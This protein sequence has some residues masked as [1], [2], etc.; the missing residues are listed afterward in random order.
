MR[1]FDQLIVDWLVNMNGLIM[2]EFVG[3]EI[4]STA[5]VTMGSNNITIPTKLSMTFVPAIRSN[6]FSI[7]YNRNNKL[8]IT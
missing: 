3:P 7:K 1:V 4:L 8:F 6:S 2:D 5:M